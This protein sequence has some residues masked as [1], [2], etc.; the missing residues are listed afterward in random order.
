MLRG[1]F[2]VF[3]DLKLDVLALS[4]QSAFHNGIQ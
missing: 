2:S 3:A 4:L 1:L